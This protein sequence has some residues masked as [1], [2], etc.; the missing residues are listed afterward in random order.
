MVCGAGLRVC[1]L[2]LLPMSASA[3][4]GQSRRCHRLLP[5]IT[6]QNYVNHLGTGNERGING[7]VKR[8]D[9]VEFFREGKFELLA[10]MEMKLKV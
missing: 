1:S 3:G 9:K 5:S 2:F 6:Q 10:L 7:T 4:L 8:E